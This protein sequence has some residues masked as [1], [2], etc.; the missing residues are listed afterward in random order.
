M[1]DDVLARAAADP[2]LSRALVPLVR[3]YLRY[4][5]VKGG[6]AF[7]WTRMA[8]PYLAWQ[9]HPFHAR[10]LF[11]FSVMAQAGFRLMCSARSTGLP[12]ICGPRWP[13]P[14]AS[15]RRNRA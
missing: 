4:F 6:K 12:P 15:V 9:P 14:A 13:A 2:R 10:T 7:V 1:L 11:G 3:A 5:P 8:E